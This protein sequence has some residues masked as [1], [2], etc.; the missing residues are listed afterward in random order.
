ME[1]FGKMYDRSL[2]T[3]YAGYDR[4]NPMLTPDMINGT[5]EL[6]GALFVLNYCRVLLKDKHVAG[7]SILSTIFFFGW[8]IW[9]CVFYPYYNLWASFMGGVV[10]CASNSWYIYL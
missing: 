2:I 3:S 7:L 6:C 1:S 9:N 4:M 8:G 10:I 5:I